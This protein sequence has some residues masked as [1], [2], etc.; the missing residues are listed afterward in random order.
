MVTTT[1]ITNI[2][3][4]V[5]DTGSRGPQGAQ[6]L[7]GVNAAANDAAIAANI[8]TAGTS[9]SRRAVSAFSASPALNAIA[10]GVSAANTPIVNRENLQACV[11]AA[12]DLG[13]GIRLPHFAFSIS[14]AV[15]IVAPGHIEVIGGGIEHT[16]ITQ[17]VV[18]STI[19]NVTGPN[20]TIRDVE[21]IGQTTGAVDMTG[22]GSPDTYASYCGIWL[23]AGSSG[24]RV[25]NVSGRGLHRAVRIDPGIGVTPAQVPN[26]LDIVVDGVSVDRCWVGVTGAGMTDCTIR[27]VRGTYVKATSTDGTNVGQP[28]HLVYTIDRSTSDLRWSFNVEVSDCTAWSSTYGAAFAI[29]GII[30]GSTDRMYARACHGLFDLISLQDYSVRN[31]HSTSDIYPGSG[32]ESSYGSVS[33]VSCTRLT[34]EN[35]TVRFADSD[36]GP[37][38]YS[39]STVDVTVKGL[40]VIAQRLTEDVVDGGFAAIVVKGVGTTLIE[41]I[42]SSIHA[43]I[44]AGITCVET[45]SGARIIDPKTSGNMKYG[46]LIYSMTGVT[47]DYD[48]AMLGFNPAMGTAARPLAIRTNV[49]GSK[50]LARGRALPTMYSDTLVWEIGLDLP[51]GAH[52]PSVATSGHLAT[53]TTGVWTTD[54]SDTLGRSFE[55]SGSGGGVLAYASGRSD[56]SVETRMKYGATNGQSRVGVAAR[57]VNASNF[58]GLGFSPTGLELSKRVAGAETVLFAVASTVP[59]A[60][61]VYRLGMQVFG[62]VVE[63]HLGGIKVGTYAL[64]GSDATL[65]SGVMDHGFYSNRGENT[66]WFGLEIRSLS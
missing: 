55:S 37:G 4:R 12:M 14:G 36:H 61:R 27:N 10:F 60:G 45:G 20:V 48:S 7:P 33:P 8:G 50:I 46:V 65:F 3:G 11:D 19:F 2:R 52:G 42:V 6:G 59:V 1:R 16:K 9:E 51:M 63:I 64:T 35:I 29:K 25:Y 30:G 40:E 41:P 22:G 31:S 62:N 21:F 57:V 24:A 54:L 17:T 13:W 23:N 58:L 66:R 39:L 49:T 26:L 28:P 15:N 44:N 56:V 43:N 38:F 34:L 47:V 5:G 32:S 18:P 53:T